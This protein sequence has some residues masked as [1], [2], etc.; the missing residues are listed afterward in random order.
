VIKWSARSSVGT[1]IILA[2]SL[3]F[4]LVAS[5]QP[6]A[7]E[8]TQAAEQVVRDLA[9]DVW[10]NAGPSNA[11]GRRDRL[12][13]AIKARTN[14]D[15]LSRLALG[16]YWR[17]LGPAQQ[18]AYQRLFSI[19]IMNALA[20]RL[21]VYLGE[22]AGPLTD[23][24]RIAGSRR[25][26]KLDVLVRSKVTSSAGIPL[27]VDWRLRTFE[28]GPVIIDLII[29]GVSLLVSQRA[30]FAAVIE[31]DRVDGLIRALERRAPG[32]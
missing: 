29:E 30:E 14:I 8:A 18:A 27:A 19:V 2:C 3:V 24:F 15:V 7:S 26:G 12:A 1:A 13:D 22:L 11:I 31:R 28:S 10:A 9:E 25:A 5:Q 23:Y 16:K 6:S 17:H 32:S 20:D 4:S 21:D